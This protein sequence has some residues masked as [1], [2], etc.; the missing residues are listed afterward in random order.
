MSEKN[1]EVAAPYGGGA[2]DSSPAGGQAPPAPVKR[3]RT[4][5]LR[6]MK[7]RGEKVTMLTA[8]DMYTAQTFDEAGVDMLLVGDRASN[9]VLGNETSLPRSEEHTSELQSL[10]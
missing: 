6:E 3:V 8:Y 10:M 7:Q 4:H 5:H 9:N 2:K 1:A